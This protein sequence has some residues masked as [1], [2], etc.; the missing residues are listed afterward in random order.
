[1]PSGIGKLGALPG[2]LGGSAV[3]MLA[4]ASMD[5]LKIGYLYTTSR[6]TMQTTASPISRMRTSVEDGWRESSRTA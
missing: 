2:N 1:V 6:L 3:P 5:F 4:F